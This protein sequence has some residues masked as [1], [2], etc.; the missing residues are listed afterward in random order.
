MII[1]FMKGKKTFQTCL[2]L[3]EKVS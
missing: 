1:S 2:A 3:C